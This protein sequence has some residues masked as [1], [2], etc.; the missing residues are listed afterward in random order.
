MCARSDRFSDH[1]RKKEEKKTTTYTHYIVVVQWLRELLLRGELCTVQEKATI[2]QATTAVL[3]PYGRKMKKRTIREISVGKS[4]KD[5]CAGV[6]IYFLLRSYR[7]KDV[8]DQT[9]FCVPGREREREKKELRYHIS[10]LCL[11]GKDDL[12]A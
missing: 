9:A 10:L 1:S 5:E 8:G 7:I 11:F 6:G 12:R 2:R 3:W 4:W